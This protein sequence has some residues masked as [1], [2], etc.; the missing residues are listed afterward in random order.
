MKLLAYHL[1]LYLAQAMEPSMPTA[2]VLI[3]EGFE[4]IETLTPVDVLRRAGVDVTLAALKDGIHVTGRSGVTIHADSPL[5]LVPDRYGFDLLLLPGGPQVKAMRADGRA[6]ALARAYSLAGKRVAAI[7]AAPQLLVDA[8][9]LEGK[10]FTSY[11][12]LAL[13][14]SQQQSAVVTDGLLTTSRGAGTSLAFAL[15][16]VSLLCGPTSAAD[17]AESIALNPT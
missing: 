6:A 8:A 11:P 7:C 9:L 10:S 16:L 5:S 14:G 1:P 17:V 4:E 13:P 3:T 15:E 12:S 2:L